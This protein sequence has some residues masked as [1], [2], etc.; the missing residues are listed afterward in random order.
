MRVSASTFVHR[1]NSDGK[2]DSICTRCITVIASGR[3]EGELER[4]ESEH[5]CN[6]N[7]LD[8]LQDL[9]LDSHYANQ[10]R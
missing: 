2:I 7:R 3:R 4:A 8:D 10:S 9:M 1:Q 5:R 6:P